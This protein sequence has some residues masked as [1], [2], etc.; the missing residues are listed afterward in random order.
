MKKIAFIASGYINQSEA[1]AICLKNIIDIMKDSIKVDIISIE[2]EAYECNSD[3]IF[4]IKQ[5]NVVE[6][7][8]IIRKIIKFM[9]M[10][11]G[12]RRLSK[13]VA[14][15]VCSLLKKRKYDALIAVVNPVESADAIY[16]IKRRNPQQKVILYEID[17][18]SNRYKEARSL[19]EKVWKFKSILWEKKIYEHCDKIIHMKTHSSHFSQMCFRK[20]QDKVLYLDIPSFRIDFLPTI[21]KPDSKICM[22]YAGAFYPALRNPFP[23]LDVLKKL[24]RLVPISV[25][26]FTGSGMIEQIKKY[27]EDESSF[28]VSNY[29][30]QDALR[31]E[32]CKADFLLDLGNKESDFLPSKTLQY[33][34]TGKPIIHFMPD[35]GDVAV[36]YLRRYKDAISVFMDTSENNINSIVSFIQKERLSPNICDSEKLM[37]LFLENTPQYTAKKLMEILNC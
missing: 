15:R 32:L 3:G 13:L 11:V 17:P 20:Y 18:A 21:S 31:L 35:T 12:S 25:K 30:S 26:I 28:F 22:V 10:P 19:F 5:N 1:N 36:D 23:M 34:G 29:I 8:E 27:V 9:H 4:A 24:N 2:K 7:N 14:R 16:Y 6:K 33:M 37:Q